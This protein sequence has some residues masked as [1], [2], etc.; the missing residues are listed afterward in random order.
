M[1]NQNAE[2][3]CHHKELGARLFTE[4]L[5]LFELTMGLLPY[6]TFMHFEKKVIPKALNN[7]AHGLE[8]RKITEQVFRK[9]LRGHHS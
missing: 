7:S 8:I 5:V 9:E 6:F 4:F 3:F 2:L 1:L